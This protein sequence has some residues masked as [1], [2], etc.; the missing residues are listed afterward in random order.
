[1]D[2]LIDGIFVIKSKEIEEVVERNNIKF[3]E[4]KKQQRE[5][6]MKVEKD[7]KQLTEDGDTTFEQLRT[8]RNKS[9]V[10]SK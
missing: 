7:I 10:F 8:L 1:M 5:T 9:N 2:Q 6:M 4:Y 3:T